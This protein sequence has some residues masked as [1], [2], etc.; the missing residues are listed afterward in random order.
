MSAMMA[1]CNVNQFK[2]KRLMK[3]R[4]ITNIKQV[5]R[6]FKSS[7]FYAWNSDDI[8]GNYGLTASIP[9]R[10]RFRVNNLGIST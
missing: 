10:T 4:K 5:E 9:A 8:F 2:V 1:F 7:A 6:T 3:D